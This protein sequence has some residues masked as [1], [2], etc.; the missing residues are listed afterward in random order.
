MSW[1]Q[2]WFVHSIVGK[3]EVSFYLSEISSFDWKKN[4]KEIR[5]RGDLQEYYLLGQLA[6]KP[7]KLSRVLSAWQAVFKAYDPSHFKNCI[8]QNKGI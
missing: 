4:P 7:I 3:S 8:A 6:L 5:I 2:V 1:G